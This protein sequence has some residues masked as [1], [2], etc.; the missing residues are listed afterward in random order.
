ML[1]LSKS[2]GSPPDISNISSVEDWA[3]L[4]HTHAPID[5][6]SLANKYKAATGPS[7]VFDSSAVGPITPNIIQHYVHGNWQGTMQV[8]DYLSGIFRRL[9]IDPSISLLQQ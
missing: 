3:Y 8:Q 7:V 1:S 2:N 5:F 6:A 9:G 4:M